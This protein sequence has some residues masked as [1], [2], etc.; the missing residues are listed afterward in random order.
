[1]YKLK[2]KRQKVGVLVCRYILSYFNV[3]YTIKQLSISLEDHTDYPS[4]LSLHDV[5]HEYGIVST[6]IRKGDFSY[7]DVETPYISSIQ[8]EDWPSADFTVVIQAENNQITYLDPITGKTK[9]VSLPDFE[10]VD[11]GIL[12]LIDAESPKDESNYLV[13]LSQENKTQRL[14]ALL[15]LLVG[16]FL[17]TPLVYMFSASIL[18]GMRWMSL[19]ILISGTVGLIS[20]LL[21]LWHDIDAHNPFFKEVCGGEGK[22]VNCGAVLNSKGANFLGISWSVYGG[23]Y[24]LSFFL[25]QL[26]YPEEVGR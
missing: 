24:F 5:L 20:S 12:L 13:N 3:K 26:L 15:F 10:K 9:T 23:A 1:M 21:L 14:R 22:K 19:S 6:A 17:L 8:Q 2:P 11:K 4:L 25:V 7:E 18:E 16:L